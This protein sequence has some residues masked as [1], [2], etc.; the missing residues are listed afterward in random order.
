MALEE[1]SRLLALD[2]SLNI[3]LDRTVRFEAGS[4]IGTNGIQIPRLITS[5][6]LDRQGDRLKQVSQRK[7]QV[8]INL[9]ETVLKGMT[10]STGPIDE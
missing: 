4:D 5:R 10:E 6:S 9:V 1:L 8:K 7:N 2:P 3:Y